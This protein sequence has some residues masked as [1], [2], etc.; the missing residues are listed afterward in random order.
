VA[1][2]KRPSISVFGTDY[3]TPDGTCIRDYVHVEDL[4]S[5][6]LAALDCLARG[7]EST[8]CNL[9]NGTGYSVREVIDTCREVTGRA[10]TVVEADRRPGDP[11]RLVA[12]AERAHKLL[13]WKPA[14]PEL[15]TMV[16]DAWRW[17]A[18]HPSGYGT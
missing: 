6:H 3:D 12:S 14:K 16:E 17:H 1:S 9:G 11:A 13:G 2:G 7:G 15:R 4:A 8:V 5:A 10:I 18:A